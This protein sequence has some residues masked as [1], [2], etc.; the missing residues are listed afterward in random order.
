MTAPAASDPVHS[1]PG[2]LVAIVDDDADF[3][4]DMADA[5]RAMGFSAVA[6]ADGSALATCLDSA[7]QT[8]DL[9]LLDLGLEREDGTDIARRLHRSTDIPVI[10]LTAHTEPAIA[11]ESLSAGGDAFL[12]KGT[13]LAVIAATIRAV[14]RRRVPD[15]P[16][17]DPPPRPEP[18]A[19]PEPA[20]GITI[21]PA[22]WQ[23][24]SRTRCLRTPGGVDIPLTHQE[25]TLLLA[26]IEADGDT[27][28]RATI[29]ARLARPDTLDNARNLD[30]LVRRCRRKVHQASG[31]RIP[32]HS[33]YAR[34]YM[35]PSG[36]MV[37][38]V[39]T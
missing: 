30:S 27:C 6:L 1:P 13:D 31:E 8:P 23:L 3:R 33:L 11:V 4:M 32:L 25:F 15:H 26:L 14:L 21:G 12:T 5:L 24:L 39:E 37:A 2:P 34:G 9:V 7:G 19:R 22:P 28:T 10:I 29:N 36:S 17:P 20:P 16:A 18:P 35:I 38:R